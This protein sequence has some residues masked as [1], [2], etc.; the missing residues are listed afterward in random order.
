LKC[1]VCVFDGELHITWLSVDS[2]AYPGKIN[3]AFYSRKWDPPWIVSADCRWRR[4]HC[5][6]PPAERSLER[7][8]GRVRVIRA[9]CCRTIS[10]R[11]W[12]LPRQTYSSHPRYRLSPNCEH[13]KSVKS[14]I[15]WSIDR[16][17]LI[18]SFLNQKFR[19]LLFAN[20]ND[21]DNKITRCE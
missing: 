17:Y 7:R 1:I 16:F 12:R 21:A 13:F 9:P 15:D 5:E 2:S 6:S 14:V 19:K 10:G 3:Y 20:F 11:I 4:I 8:L 18:R